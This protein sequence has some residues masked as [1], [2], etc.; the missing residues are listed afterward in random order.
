V[1]LTVG[2]KRFVQMLK[3]E[4]LGASRDQMPNARVCW[5][6]QIL[7][8]KPLEGTQAEENKTAISSLGSYSRKASP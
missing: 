3:G 4:L 7:A 6:P 8:K 5:T 2:Y 1:A